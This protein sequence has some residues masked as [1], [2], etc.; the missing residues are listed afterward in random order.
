MPKNT[1][2]SEEVK[3]RKVKEAE[4]FWK[5]YDMRWLKKI[6]AEHPDFEL[7][8]KYEKKHGVIEL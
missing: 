3:V 5:G 4:G 2:I 1:N 7:V 6:G 8:A